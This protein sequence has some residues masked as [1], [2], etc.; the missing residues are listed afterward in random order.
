M[1]VSQYLCIRGGSVLKETSEYIEIHSLREECPRCGS[2]LAESL[3]RRQV[4]PAVKWTP[5]DPDRRYIAEIKIRYL[6]DRLVHRPWTRGSVLHHRSLC[7]P[8]SDK[9]VGQVLVARKTRRSEFTL[10]HGGRRRQPL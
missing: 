4:Q 2:L 6:H 3:Q 10:H 8:Y 1:Q 9:A 5:R 7:K